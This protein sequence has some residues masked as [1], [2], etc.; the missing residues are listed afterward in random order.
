MSRRIMR[1]GGVER[2]GLEKMKGADPERD[3]RM[4]LSPRTRNF[5]SLNSEETVN[6]LLLSAL[7]LSFPS[8]F[9]YP[10]TL[11]RL[12]IDRKDV[13]ELV[14]IRMVERKKKKKKLHA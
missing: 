1:S 13:D 7:T 9:L 12:Q 5:G 6:H 2:G 8:L 4:Q 3:P 14:V 11:F 10:A